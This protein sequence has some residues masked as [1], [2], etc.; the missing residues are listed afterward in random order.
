VSDDERAGLAVLRDM[1]EKALN[2]FLAELERS[3]GMTPHVEGVSPKDAQEALDAL[4]SFYQVR[5][6]HEVSLDEFVSDILESLEAIPDW[7]QPDHPGEFKKRLLRLFDIE[8]L[9]LA[10]KA[11]LLQFEVE[12]RF[13]GARILTDIRPVFGSDVTAQPR[14]AIVGH[15]LRLSYH[16][17]SDEIREIYLAMDS[18]DISV[19]GEVL[20]RAQKKEK[21]LAALVETAHLRLIGRHE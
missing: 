13:H 2:E 10:A 21:T 4:T 18:V 6:Y 12:R 14:A 3:P 1:P 11:V 15:T 20:E 19:L 17:S 8:A 5:S 7:K 9:A 16:D